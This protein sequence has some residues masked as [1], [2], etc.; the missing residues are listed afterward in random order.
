MVYIISQNVYV[1]LLQIIS[2][3]LGFSV[4]DTER[5][6]QRSLLKVC[7]AICVCVHIQWKLWNRNMK[8][9]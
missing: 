8:R 4:V 9:K 5:E 7:H 2:S 3:R 6:A 1:R